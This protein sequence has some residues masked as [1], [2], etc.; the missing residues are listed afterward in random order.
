MTSTT[1]LAISI[2]RFPLSLLVVFIHSLGTTDDLA[3][4]AFR[5]FFSNYFCSFVVPTFF[6][7]SGYL[8]FLKTE[9]SFTSKLYLK[10]I[11]TRTITLL[12]PYVVWNLLAVLLDFIKWY[13]GQVSWLNY[14]EESFSRLLLLTF[15]GDL[16]DASSG[17]YYPINLPLWYIRDLMVLCLLTPLIY[18]ICK[19]IGLL[20]LVALLALYLFGINFSYISITGVLFFSVGAFLSIHKQELVFQQCYLM[21]VLA[22]V[23]MGLLIFFIAKYE[24]ALKLYICTMPFL[25]FYI[26]TKLTNCIRIFGSLSK[27]S[28]MI[29][30]SHFPLTLIL[31]IKMIGLFSDNY[32]IATY[33]ITPF[34]A[35]FLSIL[36][37]ETYHFLFR[38]WNKIR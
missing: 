13:I 31:A 1:S 2:S 29:F 17:V 8:F 25:V 24:M 26:S 3:F 38:L 4:F 15:F 7:I 30:Y 21:L 35:V 18:V 16:S 11:R 5:D 37:Y 20:Y 22:L 28:T 27:Y 10:K 14:G 33:F 34:I 6:I 9:E 23:G 32:S 19:R 36:L 12:I